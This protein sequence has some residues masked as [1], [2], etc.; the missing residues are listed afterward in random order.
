ME[1]GLQG[2]EVYYPN[3]SNNTISYY[4]GLARKYRLI[5]TGGSDSH[6]TAKDNTFIGKIKIPYSIVTQLKEAAK[7]HD[8]D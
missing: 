7:N 3:Y 5:A 6:G 2:I 8:I 4:E 1:A